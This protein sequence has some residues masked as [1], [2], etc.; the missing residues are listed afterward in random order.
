MPVFV[1]PAEAFP[2]MAMFPVGRSTG[3]NMSLI[4]R[5]RIYRTAIHFPPSRRLWLSVELA[6][7]PFDEPVELQLL[8]ERLLGRLLLR[9]RK[10]G[11]LARCG[12]RRRS[13][14]L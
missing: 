9:R 1:A 13:F 3:V 8:R 4:G 5:T 14:S 10:R 2:T 11:L 7:E 12:G 6:P